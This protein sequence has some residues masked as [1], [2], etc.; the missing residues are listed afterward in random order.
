[1]SIELKPVE[2]IGVEK[3]QTLD[4]KSFDDPRYEKSLEGKELRNLRCNLGLSLAAAAARLSIEV[5]EVSGLEQGRFTCDWAKARELLR[6]A[7][8]RKRHAVHVFDID[9]LPDDGV[10]LLEVLATSK[11]KAELTVRRMLPGTKVKALTP[12][13]FSHDRL[14]AEYSEAVE[15]IKKMDREDLA[16]LL[17][18]LGDTLLSTRTSEAILAWIRGGCTLDD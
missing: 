10:L 14:H 5:S 6:G 13:E 3:V 4:G 9:A 15:T 7:P 12:A 1:M 8:Q 16:V 18:H 2:P 17:V 11:E